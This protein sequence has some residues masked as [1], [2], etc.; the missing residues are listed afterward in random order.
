MLKKEKGGPALFIEQVFKKEGVDFNAN[1][2]A[3]KVDILITSKGEFGK[4]T[5]KPKNTE[6]DFLKM[7]KSHVV[8]SS[9]LDDFSFK[10]IEKFEEK[11]FLDIQGYVR[12]GDQFGKKK[13][14]NIKHDIGKSI[15]CMKGTAEEIKF[16]PNAIINNQKKKIL[17]ITKGKEGCE[18]F[19]FGKRYVL[20][21]DRIIKSDNTVGAGDTFFAYFISAFIKSEDVVGSVQYAIKK[22]SGFLETKIKK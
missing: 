10:N 14:W 11:I 3:G 18:I 19:A 16:I 4:I 21:P 9:L 12:N 20:K 1:T 13:N 15:F 17:L 5:Q 6:I 8:I 22:T 7:K 2:S